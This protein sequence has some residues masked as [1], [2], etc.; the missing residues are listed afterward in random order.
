MRP[1]EPQNNSLRHSLMDLWN[2]KLPDSDVH[3]I[4]IDPTKRQVYIK[5]ANDDKVLALFRA[6]NRWNE[7]KYAIGQVSSIN[8]SH[9]IRK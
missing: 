5:I 7:Y 1:G 3:M 4:Q 9:A 2:V 6:T 8:F